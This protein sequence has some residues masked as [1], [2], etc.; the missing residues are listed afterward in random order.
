VNCF[1]RRSIPYK[2]RQVR[3]SLVIIEPAIN[4][5]ITIYL[6]PSRAVRR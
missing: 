3:H 5:D 6:K 4:Y 2:H 1:D